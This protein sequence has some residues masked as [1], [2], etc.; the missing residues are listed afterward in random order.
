MAPHFEEAQH[1]A[2]VQRLEEALGGQ[3]NLNIAL[4]GRYGTGKSSVLDGF[5][6][7][8]KATT[9]RLAI[10]TL[11]PSAEG[12]TLTNR[13]QKELV[14]Q[15]LYS[16][17]ARTVRH[18]RFR[19]IRPLSRLRAVGES[20]TAVGLLGLLLGLLGWLPSPAWAGA[21]QP[22]PVRVGLWGLVGSLM[23]VPLAVTRLVTYDRFF[24]SDLS[25]AGASVKLSTKTA[26]YF[27]EY[28]DEIVHFFNAEPYDI[29]IL[30]DLDRFDDPQIFE[31]LRE[32]NTLLNHTPERL[33]KDTPL[34]F[35]YAVRDSLFEQLGADTKEKASDA[36]V[37]ETVRANRT[38]FFDLVIPVVPFISHRNA[39]E[40]LTELLDKAGV[41]TVD[42]RLVDLVAR[43]TTDM[44]LLMN[45]RN[46]YLVFAERLLESDS[47]A[48]ELNASK[49]FALVAYKNFHLRDFEQIARRGS[50]LDSLYTHRRDLVRAAVAERE[51]RKRDLAA[52]RVRARSIAPVA[53][54]VG[55]RLRALGQAALAGSNWPGYQLRFSVSST[56]YDP[57]ELASTEFWAEAAEAAEVV[58][59]AQSHPGA[60]PQ[61]V[62]TLGEDALGA[63]FPEALTKNRWD[64]LGDEAA[65]AELAE[66]DAD[67]AFLR[68]ADFHDLA[69]AG[70]FTFR[71]DETDQTFTQIIDA[72]MKSD[73]ARDLVK[74]GYLDRNFPLYAA[75]FYGHFTGVDVA[76]FIVQTVQTHTM[77][78]DY[79]FTSPASVANLLDEASEDFTQ[80]ISA[81][82]IAV[83]D[84]L[85]ATSDE[86]A[87]NIV[88]HLIA[89][90]DDPAQEFVTAYLTSG[91][92]RTRLAA[93]LSGRRWR[94]VFPYLVAS[95]SVPDDVRPE[96]VN[97]A[98]LAGDPEAPY[99]LGLQVSEFLVEHYPSM[100]AF[101]EAHDESVT[102]TVATL[103]EQAD[104]SVPDLEA[105][106]ETLREQVVDRN[107]YRLTAP[108]LRAALDLTGDVSLDRV[109]ANK[110]VYQYCLANPSEYLS[111]VELD[112]ETPHA[113]RTT[114][115]L[116]A[117]LSEVADDWN[118]DQVR[119]LAD[120]A[121]TESALQR[122]DEVPTSSWPALAAAKLFRP[123]LA[124]LEAYRAEVG[125]IDAHLAALLLEAGQID[126]DEDEAAADRQPDKVAAAVALLNAGDTIREP[127]DRVTLV[128]SLN[129]E[130]PLTAA[131]LTPEPSHLF[132]LLLQHRLVADDATSFSHFHEAGWEAMG[133]AILASDHIEEFLTA[134]LVEAM[135]ADLFR[136]PHV[137]DKVGRLVLEDLE[138][139]VPDDD[140]PALIAAADFAVDHGVPLPL[141]QVRRVAATGQATAPDLTVRLLVM[142]TPPPTAD[143]I[144]ATLTELGP[145]YNNLTTHSQ[146][147]FDVPDDDAH[148]A[149]FQTLTAA[150]ICTTRRKN[151]HRVVK[152]A[153]P[154]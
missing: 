72:T 69:A 14:K 54:K 18:S 56:R 64:T 150:D 87:T 10:S 43:H 50:D 135:V 77:D 84:H 71:V 1:R 89:D 25:A 119:Q 98:L 38:K 83:L 44:R 4:T 67:I 97:A 106:H 78:I 51:K 109:R 120:G 2:Y 73:L 65:R 103:L 57:D 143:D 134:D 9:L 47:P 154:A 125:T 142:A 91:E 27:D 86:R 52:G 70:G 59:L 139:F 94:K 114:E 105:V 8:H 5:E 17:T 90:F 110:T 133:P 13:I 37:A 115:T 136:S 53:R 127:A 80:T 88:D 39:R 32:L 148:R 93:Q 62:M 116:T 104:V 41:T 128:R 12:V 36:A 130:G 138:Q 107:L 144:V 42:R 66:L 75:L 16:A 140:G 29:V 149:L 102:R 60:G 153:P 132:A 81:Y 34:R 61:R 21:G 151:R 23:V 55:D 82:N 123:S 111:A 101:T 147:T 33:K 145:P 122:L 129:L 79:R 92:Q 11:A 113:V 85:L 141:D 131:N 15:L 6:Q 152:L 68:G 35:V 30:E 22:W 121:A 108:N 48:P 49:L 76:T 96:L 20:A 7:N 58:I 117:V 137:R 19:R 99:D 40:L 112:D 26:T 3:E 146:T 31:A 126:T 100:S 24:V 74:R 95:E 28:L 124:N 118:P 46:E 63:L 45:M